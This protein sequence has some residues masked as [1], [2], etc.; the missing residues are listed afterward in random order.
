MLTIV[1]PAAS[2]DL[3]SLARVKTE[4][5]ITGTA[6][7]AKLT[8]L[9]AEASNLITIYCK[10]NS[11]GAQT[12]RQTERLSERLECIVLALDLA[13][14]IASVTVDGV[15]LL[16]TEWEL[17]GALLYRLDASDDRRMWWE[18]GTKVV[19]QYATGWTLPAGAPD[20]LERAAVDLVANL[21][22]AA[23]RDTTVRSE[24]VEGIGSISYVDGRSTGA[25][26]AALPLAPDRMAAVDFYRHASLV[27]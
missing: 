15:A 8:T 9:I 6:E 7:D 10:R 26:A 2:D 25:N 12:V 16:T 18:G 1:T 23:G 14:V 19:I 3:T 11:F 4:L 22:R 27:P 17:D 24:T 13:V 20:A 21:Y 5:G